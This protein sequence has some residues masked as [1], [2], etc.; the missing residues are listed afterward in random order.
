[1]S[2][3]NSKDIF[4]YLVFL[5]IVFFYWYLMSMGQEHETTLN[6]ETA[7]K[8]VPSE[9]VVTEQP[10]KKIAV[11]VK[12]KG[13]NLL[14]Y[15]SLRR[16]GH[17]TLDYRA[18][19]PRDGAVVYTGNALQGLLQNYFSLSQTGVIVS[20]AP[21]TLRYCVADAVGRRLP[22]RLESSVP[23]EAG[24]SL[25]AVRLEPDSVTVY[26]PR[27]VLDT[28]R[29]VTVR[30][31]IDAP[32]A[33][34]TLLTLPCQR[35][36]TGM[37]VEPE[38][39]EATFI[40]SPYVEKTLEVT[41]TAQNVPQGY[42]LKLFPSKATVTC[43]V[44]LQDFRAVTA[45]SFAVGVDYATLSNDGGRMPVVVL[46][47]TPLVK[48]VSVQPTEVDGLLETATWSDFASPEE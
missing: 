31:T 15:R 11:T 36:V 2:K 45:D 44:S 38:S 18:M 17:L 35:T 40:V 26:A 33:D 47:H 22:V 39:V 25:H 12:D 10:A 48:S 46:G 42:S 37:M 34:S 16:R 28:L 20:V 27:A 9:L 24:H 6:V 5:L 13:R 43:L 32:L 14:S 30:A 1:M 19:T 23:I 8:H 29:A 21:D 3:W 7:L 4:V 41:L